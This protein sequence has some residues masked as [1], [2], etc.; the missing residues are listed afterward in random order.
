MFSQ[1]QYEAVIR[2][3]ESGMRT[4]ETNLDKIP[5][6]AHSATNHWYVTPPVADAIN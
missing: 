6:A 3:I 2:E 1:A 5:P 4:F